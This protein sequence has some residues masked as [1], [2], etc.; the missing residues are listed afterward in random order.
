MDRNSPNLARCL[1]KW[2][3]SNVSKS[4]AQFGKTKCL[5]KTPCLGSMNFH[6]TLFSPSEEIS[7]TPLLSKGGFANSYPRF[8]T[9]TTSSRSA[10]F[11]AWLHSNVHRAW[12]QCSRVNLMHVQYITIHSKWF[13]IWFLDVV[14]VKSHDLLEDGECLDVVRLVVHAPWFGD[15][16]SYSL[17]LVNWSQRW[18]RCINYDLIQPL[19]NCGSALP[20][21]FA[22]STGRPDFNVWL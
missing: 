17:F 15:T 16:G 13:P 1:T 11:L 6:L 2:G 4:F 14:L 3:L 10:C 5:D 22:R 21:I 9:R 8:A 7:P 18:T 12:I 20:R 19:R